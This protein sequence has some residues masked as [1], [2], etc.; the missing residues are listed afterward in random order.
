MEGWVSIQRKI[1]DHWIWDNDNYLKAWLW[2]IFRANIVT[3]K[4]LISGKL[5]TVRRGEFITS[6]ANI[7]SNTRLTS[8]NVRT[9]LKLL[10]NEK[11]INKQSTNKLTKITICNYD[12]YQTGQQADNKQTNKQ[13]TIKQQA[14]NKQATTEN[15]NNNV[16]ND[17]NKYN[18][19]KNFN[20]LTGKKIRVF[21][22][23]AKKQFKARLKEGF[24]IKEIET[25]IV[26]CSN[27]QYHIENPRFLTPEFITRLDKL[28]KYIQP[29]QQKPNQ[30]IILPQS[31]D[32]NNYDPRKR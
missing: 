28:Q 8:Q 7:A 4:V 32:L 30:Q 26:N 31:K 14:A 6:I 10:E 25:A 29:N 19:I 2:M 12:S 20:L 1:V 11:M 17:N 16:N 13:T 22:D 3:N 27:D 9:L 15:N 24:T 18:F 5:E 21:D 23:K